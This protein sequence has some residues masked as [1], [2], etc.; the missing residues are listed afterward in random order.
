MAVEAP[1]QN[2]DIGEMPCDRKGK[3]GEGQPSD[4]DLAPVASHILY[5]QKPSTVALRC[6]TE[7][8]DG[9]SKLADYFTLALEPVL[10][11]AVSCEEGGDGLRFNPV[12]H[13]DR[14]RGFLSHNADLL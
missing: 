12:D 6:C 14:L 3:S 1:N 10:G 4:A 5:I 13:L 9:F 2:K 7:C 8:L 11:P